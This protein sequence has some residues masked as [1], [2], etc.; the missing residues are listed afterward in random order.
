MQYS[1]YNPRSDGTVLN[2]KETQADIVFGF[3]MTS[4]DG[5]VF[6]ELEEEYGYFTMDLVK[7]SVPSPILPS[8]PPSG[9]APSYPNPP[10][11]GS[12][13]GVGALTTCEPSPQFNSA[14]SVNQTIELASATPERNPAFF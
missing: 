12:K 14:F 11:E 7:F 2:F 6:P 5:V 3:G 4:K 9:E 10:S 13:S 8:M 1:I